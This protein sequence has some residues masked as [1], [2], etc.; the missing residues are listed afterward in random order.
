V[1]GQLMPRSRGR[2]AAR[3][4]IC[5]AAL[6]IALIGPSTAGAAVRSEFYGIVQG[7]TLDDKDVQA[8]QNSHVHVVRYLFS[9]ESVQPTSKTK[10]N[11]GLHDKFIGRLAAKGIRV[12]PAIW[13]NP[14]WVSGYTARPPIDRTQDQTAWQAFLKAVVARYG[15]GGNFWT[16]RFHRAY[17]HATPLPLTA[18]QIWNEP[19][20]KKYFVPYPAPKQYGKLLKLSYNAIH[21]KQPGAQIVLGGM[22]G[23]GDVNAWDFLSQMYNQVA[24]IKNYFDVAALHPYAP[25]LDKMKTEIQKFRA[26]MTSHSDGA[27]PLWLTEIGWGSAP[28][29]RFGIN[30]GLKGQNTMLKNSFGLIL[31]HQNEWRVGRLFWFDWRDPSKTGVV[32][33]SFCASAGLLRYNRTPKP[34]YQTFK[35]YANQG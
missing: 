12:L 11:W 29:D 5:L 10:F 6:G 13:G 24:G 18:Y 8:L 20:L 27:T 34:A 14:N 21:S 9:W 4:A 17:P 32:K 23:F 15:A 19:N 3:L 22:P 7:P 31:A 35:F 1:D 2:I 26:S 16:G 25:S 28:P 33:C 30:Q